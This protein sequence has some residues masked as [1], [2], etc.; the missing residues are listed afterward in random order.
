MN[1]LLRMALYFHLF[2]EANAKG[3]T[4]VSRKDDW[5]QICEFQP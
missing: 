4:V 5:K 3:W 2:D 1:K